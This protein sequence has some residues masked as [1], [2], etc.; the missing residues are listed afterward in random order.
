MLLLFLI[1]NHLL[2]CCCRKGA[3]F[4]ISLVIAIALLTSCCS[5]GLPWFG[6][7]IPC[8]THITVSCPNTDE[9][10]NY[11]SFQCPPGYYND[12]ASLFLSTNDDAIRNLFSASTKKNF[13]YPLSSSFS[14]LFIVLALLH[15][16]L[17]SHLDFSSPLF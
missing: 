16:E 15:M 8:P 7:C 17:L 14:L 13:V 9:S 11:K 5:Y 1:D 4:K 3:A 6:R 2:S 12:I 10:G